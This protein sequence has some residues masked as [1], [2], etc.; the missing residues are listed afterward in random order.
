MRRERHACLLVYM[1]AHVSMGSHVWALLLDTE[2]HV[3]VPLFVPMGLESS[4]NMNLDAHGFVRVRKCAD[5]WVGTCV[6][7]RKCV[8]VYIRGISVYEYL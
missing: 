1:G 6:H 3:C 2:A 5:V 4:L 8:H 7:V